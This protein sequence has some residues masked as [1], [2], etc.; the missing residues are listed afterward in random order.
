MTVDPT[1]VRI[2]PF[3]AAYAPAFRNLNVE[4]ISHYFR[5]EAADYAA[6]DDPQSYI[7]DRG[8]YIF[9]ALLGDKPV[10]TCALLRLTPDSAYDYELA[11]MAVSPRVQGRGIGYRLGRAVIEKARS[12][13]AATLYL[14]SNSKLQP[15]LSLYRKLGFQDVAGRSSPYERCDV[16]M[17]LKLSHFTST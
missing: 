6:L 12:L 17:E 10:G 15:A 8:G 3:S 13:G 2:V 5:M 7:L 1:A 16:Q 14:E 9:M 11:K 4:W